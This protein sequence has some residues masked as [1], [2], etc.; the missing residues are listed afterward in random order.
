MKPVT[1]RHQGSLVCQHL[2][3]DKDREGKT[4]NPGE[5][6]FHPRSVCANSNTSTYVFPLWQQPNWKHSCGEYITAHHCLPTDEKWR[7]KAL[8]NRS[9]SYLPQASAKQRLRL[10]PG[11]LLLCLKGEQGYRELCQLRKQDLKIWFR[12]SQRGL[13]NNKGIGQK[14]TCRWAQWC[15]IIYS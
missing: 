3:A 4:G 9:R 10:S 6:E 15:G 2:P 11:G 7:C 14:Q 1:V 8:T 13:I 12:N 5:P